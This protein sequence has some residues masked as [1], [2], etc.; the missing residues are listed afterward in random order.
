MTIDRKRLL[1][2]LM[3][4]FEAAVGPWGKICDESYQIQ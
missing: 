3:P 1:S 2:G 4:S